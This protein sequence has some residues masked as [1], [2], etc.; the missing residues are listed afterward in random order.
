M[1]SME[2]QKVRVPLLE[3]LALLDLAERRGETE[4]QALKRVIREAVRADC[5]RP[6][7][8]RTDREL[9]AEGEHGAEVARERP[10]AQP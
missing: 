6:E 9:Q 2:W 1:G 7:A 8:P 10:E 5:L 4:E 3:R